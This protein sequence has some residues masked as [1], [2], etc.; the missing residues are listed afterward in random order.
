[1]KKLISIILVL[2]MILLYNVNNFQQI[3]D[4]IVDELED[5]HISD[6]KVDINQIYNF[7]RINIGDSKE[8]VIEKLSNPNRIDKTPYNFFWYVY[9]TYKESFVMVGIKNN[10]V[11]AL[12]T[13]NID[14]CENENI[15]INK[16]IN[17]IKEHYKTL[18]YQLKGNIRYEI[19]SNN[20]YDII[21]KNKK[22]ITVFYDKYNDNKIWAYEIVEKLSEDEINEIYPNK[23]K[24]IEDS[25]M[26]EIIDLINSTRYKYGL[27]PLIYSEK[28]TKSA[29]KHSED[30]KDNNFFNHKNLKN[31]TPFDRME[32]EGISYMTAGENIAAGQVNAIFA[33]NGLMNSIG[34]RKNILGN[35]KYI[36]VGVVFGGKYKTYYTENFFG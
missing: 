23:S 3:K 30:M 13:N 9:N 14:S 19:T 11:V 31:E 20:E 8:S 12:F 22:Y 18:E 27:Q 25:F 26:Y 21:Y 28:A 17:Y 1:M 10:K 33:H 35:Y 16:D 4:Y 2:S 7:K 24:E 34:H 36:G 5:K 29:K 32:K 15:Y 6:N